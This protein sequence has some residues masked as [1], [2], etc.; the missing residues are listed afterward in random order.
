MTA[1]K[2]KIEHCTMGWRYRVVKPNFFKTMIECMLGNCRK[3]IY[4]GTLRKAIRNRSRERDQGS[5][6][7]DNRDPIIE[8]M[9]EN[10]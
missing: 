5:T 6:S 4:V 7:N 2:R 9:R 3:I 10:L 8:K 1:S